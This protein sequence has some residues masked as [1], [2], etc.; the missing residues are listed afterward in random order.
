MTIRIA[1]FQVAIFLLLGTCWLTFKMLEVNAVNRQAAISVFLEAFDSI[2]EQAARE[3]ASIRSYA[4]QVEDFL[5]RYGTYYFY[6]GWLIAILETTPIGTRITQFSYADAQITI[7]AETTDIATAEIHRRAIESTFQNAGMGRVIGL[8][9]GLYRYEL[10]I[11][12]SI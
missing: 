3:A 9:H 2:P 5:Y 12:I 7:T 1:A 10:L 4:W 6:P 8:G 11:R